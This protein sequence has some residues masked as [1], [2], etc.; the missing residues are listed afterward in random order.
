MPRYFFN[1]YD[2]H[3]SADQDGTELPDF[4]AAQSEAI[5]MSGE[6]LRDMGAR[7]WDSTEWRL[8]VATSA[9]RS[10]S[11]SASPPRSGLCRRRPLRP[12]GTVPPGRCC[13]PDAG[14]WD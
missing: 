10:C 2:G 9:A 6:I 12:R 3:V 7:F 1:V 14:S 4:Y 5:R 8:E 11:F 13:R